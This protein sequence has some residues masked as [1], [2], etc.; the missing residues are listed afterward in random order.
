MQQNSLG[1]L[2]RASQV[3]DIYWHTYNQRILSFPSRKREK[4]KPRGQGQRA[5]RKSYLAVCRTNPRR[6][7]YSFSN[8]SALG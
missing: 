3:K 1:S 2:L 5:E 6:F 7:S 4:E 8:L